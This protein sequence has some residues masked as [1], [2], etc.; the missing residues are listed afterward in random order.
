MGA[1]VAD[2]DN[3]GWID[4]YFG[5]GD[6]GL[7]R[8]EADRFYHSDGDGTYTAGMTMIATPSSDAPMTIACRT[9][10]RMA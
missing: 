1:N 2:L 10:S 7:V 9:T 5:T 4:L 8:M 6:P 3:D